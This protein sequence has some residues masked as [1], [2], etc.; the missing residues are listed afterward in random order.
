M[1]TRARFLIAVAVELGIP[2]LS[3]IQNP[4]R[5]GGVDPSLSEYL[6]NPVGKMSFSCCGSP[7]FMKELQILGRKQI[8]VIGLETHI[9]VGQ[10]ALDLQAMNYDVVV[11]PDAVSAGSLEC[12]KI[13]M[14]RI[15]DAGIVPVHTEAVAYEWLKSARHPCF[16]RVLEL[17]KQAR[18]VA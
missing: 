10:T 4:D 9:C 5:M 1:I 7:E 13:G 17:T 14:E 2:V 6:T 16:K 18:A 8:V 11:C 3:T 15:R 12:H